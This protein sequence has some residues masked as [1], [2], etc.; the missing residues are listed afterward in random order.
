MSDRHICK[1]KRTDNGEWVE[2]FC[3]EFKE[4]LYITFLKETNIH[5]T[6]TEEP[7]VVDFDMRTYEVDP[8]TVCQC[9]GLPDRNGKKIFEWDI[10]SA[11]LDDNCP[12]DITYVQIIW[13]GFAWCMRESTEDDVMTEWDCNT[14]EVCGNIFDNPELLGGGAAC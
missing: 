7:S 8:G 10:L 14:F 5:V 1:A 12:D 3:F 2:G 4:K 13:N 9:T 11:H 6:Y